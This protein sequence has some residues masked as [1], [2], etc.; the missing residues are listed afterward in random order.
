MGT[1]NEAFIKFKESLNEQIPNA[2]ESELKHLKKFVS[3][4]KDSKFKDELVDILA[5]HGIYF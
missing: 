1:I 5:A 3:Q 2:K 4:L